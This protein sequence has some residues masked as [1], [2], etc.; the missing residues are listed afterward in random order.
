MNGSIEDVIC[1]VICHIICHVTYLGVMLIDLSAAFDMLDQNI[2][3][4]KLEVCGMDV[5]A[6]SWKQLPLQ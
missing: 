1:H 6:I 3:L 4:M 2:L 5:Q